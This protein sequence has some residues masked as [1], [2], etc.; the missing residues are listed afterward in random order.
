MQTYLEICVG[1]GPAAVP[2][3]TAQF[4]VNKEMVVANEVYDELPLYFGRYFGR[5][6][7]CIEYARA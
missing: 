6:Q 1:E 2:Y 4:V 5:V 7:Q 3:T